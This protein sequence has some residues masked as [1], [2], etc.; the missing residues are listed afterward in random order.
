MTAIGRFES[1]VIPEPNSGCWLWIGA[2]SRTGYGAFSLIGHKGV[3]A[4]RA[5]WILFRGEIPAGLCVCHRR[6]NRI[7]VNPDHMFLGS[8]RENMLDCLRKGRFVTERM[9]ASRRGERH[10]RA[11]ITASDVTDIRNAYAAGEMPLKISSRYNI[12]AATISNIVARR[13][14]RHVP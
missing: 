6:D 10:G 12:S 11:K 9:L 5:A 7:C 14:W 13:K 2:L 3:P 8:H 1:Y 4:H